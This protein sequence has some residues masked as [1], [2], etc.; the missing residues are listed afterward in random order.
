VDTLVVLDHRLRNTAQIIRDNS[1]GSGGR[2]GYD[3]NSMIMTDATTILRK[4][5]NAKYHCIFYGYLIKMLIIYRNV[6]LKYTILRCM[7]CDCEAK[8]ELLGN[9]V[10]LTRLGII[11]GCVDGC[12]TFACA[13]F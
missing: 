5:E 12:F 10:S 8:L 11:P 1:R 7:Y 3:T 2:Q 6:E 4:I 13:G 9:K